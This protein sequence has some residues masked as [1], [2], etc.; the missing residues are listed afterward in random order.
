MSLERNVFAVLDRTARSPRGTQEAFSFSGGDSIT[1]VELRDRAQDLARGLLGAGVRRGDR[2]AVMMNNRRE[3]LEVVFA[4]AAA[5]CVGVPVNVLLMPD[6]VGHVI[7][8]SGARVLIYDDHVADRVAR[9]SASVDL[10]VPVATEV[11]LAQAGRTVPYEAL[12]AGAEESVTLV[13][14]DLGDPFLIYYTSGTT[15]APKGA[16]HSHGGVLWNAM[17][18]WNALGLD[19]TVKAGVISSLSWA[20]GLHVL[21]MALVWAGGSSHVRALGGATPRA[22]VDMLVDEEI[23]HTF[24]VPSLLAEIV[25]DPD[26][27]ARLRTSSLRWILT[28]SAPVPLALLERFTAALPDLALCQ[29]YGFSE[30]PVVVCVLDASEAADHVGSAGRPMPISQVAVRT[31]DGRIAATG[32]GELVVRS[33]AT[34]MEYH[35]RPEE[36]ERAFRDGWFHTGDLVDIDADGYVTITGRLKELIISGGL[37]IYPKEVED[38]LLRVEG[39]KE[40]AVVGVPD[41]KYGETAAAVL[42]VD[43]A[44]F[45]PATAQAL[46]RESLAGY[47]RPKHYLVRTDPLPRNANAKMLKRDLVPWATDVLVGQAPSDQAKATT[48]TP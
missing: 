2:V 21:V 44:D 43:S 8:D 6:E 19:A 11:A 34:M 35:D 9:V 5:G 13:G 15:G 45:D 1:F 32:K 37:N 36:T 48:W 31:S 7:A 16:L 26:L 12:I 17:G 27:V 20:A 30:F 29:G 33:L 38:V 47:K 25:E 3:W 40:C 22:V 39:V 23:T 10:A 28:G 46:C 42:V 41:E 14:P 18:Q 4:V 24:L